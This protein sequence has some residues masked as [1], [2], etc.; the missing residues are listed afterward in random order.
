MS[1]NCYDDRKRWANLE[2]ICWNAERPSL[3]A[4]V[5][6]YLGE[7]NAAIA[8]SKGAICSHQLVA[9]V[10]SCSSADSITLR[11]GRR[12]GSHILVTI[13]AIGQSPRQGA[14]ISF[15]EQAMSEVV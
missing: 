8:H 10:D 4:E 14:E 12:T 15:H 5:P 7:N 3:V 1:Y 13:A 11:R 9:A 6:N 2:R